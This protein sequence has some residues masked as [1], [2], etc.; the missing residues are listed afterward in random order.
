[1]LILFEYLFLIFLFGGLFGTIDSGRFSFGYF[2]GSGLGIFVLSVS[3]GYILHFILSKLSN[4]ENSI[5]DELLDSG[6]EENK[7]QELEKRVRDK[8]RPFKYGVY[9]ALLFLLMEVYDEFSRFLF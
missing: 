9:I 6:L 3:L 2:L 4:N 7:Y 8:L 5:D 1:L